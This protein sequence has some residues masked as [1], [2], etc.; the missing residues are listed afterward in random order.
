M[1][2]A[3]DRAT[4]SRRKRTRLRRP[5]RAGRLERRPFPGWATYTKNAI[6]IYDSTHFKRCPTIAVITIMD[7][8]TRKWSCEIVSAEETSTQV[9]VAFTDALEL[10]A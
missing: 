4:C 6:W 9:Q 2:V 8:V 1:G 5:G 7:L 3:G 10:E